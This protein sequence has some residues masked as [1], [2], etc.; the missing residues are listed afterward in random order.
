MFFILKSFANFT[1]KH[2]CWSLF[3]KN[4]QAE[5]LQLYLKKTPTRVFSCEIREI[6]KNTFFTEYLWW[7]FLHLRWLL[8]YF[9]KT[10]IAIKQL[11]CNLAM[12]YYFFFLADCLMYKKLNSFVYKFVV[13]CQVF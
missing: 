6:F 9:L 4:L 1:G 5:G 8:L 3:L 13:N 7:M 10:A 2:L 11:F 12:K